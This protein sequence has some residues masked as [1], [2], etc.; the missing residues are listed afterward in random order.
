MSG[1]KLS[2]PDH[3]GDNFAEIRPAPRKGGGGRAYEEEPEM[4]TFEGLANAS[5]VRAPEFEPEYEERYDDEEEGGW[6]DEGGG[7]E[8]GGDFEPRP[9]EFG[10]DA[11]VIQSAA[12]IRQEKMKL[13]TKLTDLAARGVP[14]PS[15][16]SLQ[17][18][19]D[20]LR[21]HVET[22][23][24]SIRLK[25]SLRFQKQMLMTTVSGVEFL[26]KVYDSPVHLNGWSHQVYSQLNDYND[27]ME[28]LHD[29]YASV[30]N[31][32]PILELVFMLGSSAFLFHISNMIVQNAAPDMA[33]A[34]KADP[35]LLALAA[36]TM[37]TRMNAGAA[38]A[39]PAPSAAPAAPTKPRMNPP[40]L[41][42]LFGGTL[43][44]A[45][46][47]KTSLPEAVQTSLPGRQT[48]M[49]IV[50]GHA[51]EMPFPPPP[52]P[53]QPEPG[54]ELSMPAT[55]KLVDY[56][57]G[58]EGHVENCDIMRISVEDTSSRRA[59]RAKKK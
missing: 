36:K 28:R 35:E 39:L 40:P 38:P 58:T 49:E 26:N 22:I 57:E 8:G 12:R 32:H 11:D 43:A 46:S 25:G 37:M 7:E 54:I 5:K 42:G 50:P 53:P 51:K 33:A 2:L 16:V 9:N 10:M 41:A 24:R 48:Q 1:K 4:D 3:A 31:F 52:A 6:D 15:D 20:E 18:N 56:A 17:T 59:T 55:E 27:V 13:L 14:V 45:S 47:N 23:E 34:M 30:V 44:G 21:H 19:I 29:R